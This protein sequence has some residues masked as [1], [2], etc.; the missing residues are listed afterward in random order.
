[1]LFGRP[2]KELDEDNKCIDSNNCTIGHC[3]E[4]EFMG[5]NEVKRSGG[6]TWSKQGVHKYSLDM[7]QGWIAMWMDSNYQLGYDDFCNYFARSN[8][9]WNNISYMIYM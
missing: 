5:S 7:K 1:M 3:S 9:Y 4:T 8:E 6:Q 2:D